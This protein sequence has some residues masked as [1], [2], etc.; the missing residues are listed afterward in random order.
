MQ[1]RGIRG[2][3]EDIRKE[4]RDIEALRDVERTPGKERRK[5]QSYFLNVKNVREAIVPITVTLV[6]GAT[7]VYPLM[8]RGKGNTYSGISDAAIRKF[9][10]Y[11]QE[12]IA[13]S[14]SNN[15][16]YKSASVM[17]PTHG[18]VEVN[19]STYP[20]EGKSESVETHFNGK[21]ILFKR[22]FT[23]PSDAAIT[24]TYHVDN[25]TREIIFVHNR[26]KDAGDYYLGYFGDGSKIFLKP[27]IYPI[28]AIQPTGYAFKCWVST[29][30]VSVFQGNQLHTYI[31]VVKPD[32]GEASPSG[33]VLALFK[34]S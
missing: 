21:D 12:P 17:T 33:G 31:K 28:D 18:A 11:A 25:H 14:I 5:R 13:I 32:N 34:R 29:G 24:L 27:G 22:V 4:A 7:L 1:I 2:C 3:V 9:I 10:A 16:K 20:T 6:I 19:L 23:G 15:P 26:H 8:K 30:N